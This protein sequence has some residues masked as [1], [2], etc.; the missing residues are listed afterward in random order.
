[1]S[2]LRVPAFDLLTEQQIPYGGFGDP[3][4]DSSERPSRLD[5]AADEAR[6]RIEKSFAINLDKP[7]NVPERLDGII[8]GMWVHG[9]S[10]EKGDINLFVGDF[11]LLLTSA[12]LKRFGGKA[13]FR[14][15]EDVSHLSVWWPEKGIEAFPFHHVLRCLL[16]QESDSN[17][18][19]VKG[20]GVMLQSK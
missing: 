19:F 12:L 9:W 13:V 4:P 7:S 2:S 16:E 5:D 6:C 11:G 20:I 3:L 15:D 18:S 1:V 8:A 14:S 10:P 17:S